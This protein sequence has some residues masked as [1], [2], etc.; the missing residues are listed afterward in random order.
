MLSTRALPRAALLT[1]SLTSLACGKDG[2]STTTTDSNSAAD[3]STGTSAADAST[4]TSAAASNPTDGPAA[5]TSATTSGDC[6]TGFLCTV[7]AG[8]GD[9]FECDVFKQDCGENEKCVA[10]GMGGSSSWNATKCVLVTGDGLPGDTCSAPEGGLAGNDDCGAG[11]FCWDVLNNQGICVA[12]CTGT[13]DA[14]MCAPEST[15]LISNEGALNLCLPSCDP[16]VQD[17]PGDDLCVP[18]ADDFFCSQDASGDEGQTNDPCQGGNVCD[19]GLLC[20]NTPTA[21][22]A[23]D[24]NSSGCCQPYCEYPDG[25]CPNPDQKC[26]Q[27]FNPA[28]LPPEDPRLDIGVCGIPQ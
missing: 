27:W 14:P 23:C 17:C 24:P 15:C 13:P 26:N 9:P 18:S 11:T 25:A 1:L 19:K 8:S 7:D 5:E 21:S 20:L 16:L 4:G 6:V 28:E 3:A 2:G 10:W 22:S 12:L